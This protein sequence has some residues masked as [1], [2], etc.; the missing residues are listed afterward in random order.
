MSPCYNLVDVGR[1]YAHYGKI[2]PFRDRPDV[3]I[4]VLWYP[5][6]LDTPSVLYPNPFVLRNWDR[7][8]RLP[9]TPIG[10]IQ[11]AP[12]ADDYYFGPLPDN[13]PGIPCGTRDM[14]E[15]GLLYQDWLDG[16]YTCRCEEEILAVYVQSVTCDDGSLDVAPTTGDVVVH[17]DTA[18][19]N[20][21]TAP[22]YFL[23]EAIV[24][25]SAT[26]TAICLEIKGDRGSGVVDNVQFWGDG[27][28]NFFGLMTISGGGSPTGYKL[29]ISNHIGCGGIFI[30]PITG[31][32]VTGP[33][34]TCARGGGAVQFQ[35]DFDGSVWTNQGFTATTPGSIVAAMPIYDATGTLLGYIP[36]YDSIT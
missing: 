13:P 21:W 30:A 2:A 33:F 10:T 5:V 4:D 17:I 34:F 19:V 7:L 14:W 6:P 29:R 15:N 25:G 28:A 16:R 35:I 8:E 3:L 22:Q 12:S 18:H 23:N 26:P 24:D 31:S 9:Q 1:D 27:R 20:E 11:D 32:P 36:I